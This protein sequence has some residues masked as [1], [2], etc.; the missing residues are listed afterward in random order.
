MDTRGQEKKGPLVRRRHLHGADPFSR[1]V[2][3]ILDF[4]KPIYA[5]EEH[6]MV[7]KYI[8]GAFSWP[9]KTTTMEPKAGKI[10]R[11]VSNSSFAALY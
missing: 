4:S 5:Y 10:Q 7:S 2:L 11:V 6:L 3:Q 9:P 8:F 1:M